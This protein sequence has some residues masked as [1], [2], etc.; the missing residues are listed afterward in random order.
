MGEGE[1]VSVEV[2]VA[3]G[4]LPAHPVPSTTSI[5]TK[6]TCIKRLIVIAPS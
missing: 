1:S 6:P 4:E 5:V 2:D 3:D